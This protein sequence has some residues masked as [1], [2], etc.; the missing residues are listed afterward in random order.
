MRKFV[1]LAMAVIGAASFAPAAHAD[2]T[3][4][5][6]YFLAETS[7][8]TSVGFNGVADGETAYYSDTY[9]EAGVIFSNSFLAIVSSGEATPPN[10]LGVNFLTWRGLDPGTDSLNQTLTLTVT[11]P[12]PVTAFGFDYA[13]GFLNNSD[14]LTITW[15]DYSYGLG[16]SLLGESFFGVVTSEPL[17]SLTI[18]DINGINIY[19]TI[20]N[21]AFE[22]APAQTVPEPASIA[23]LGLAGLATGLIRRAKTNQ[24]EN[25]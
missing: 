20:A 14:V 22:L 12:A 7:D 19:P 1:I 4:S 24:N 15:Q 13:N 2:V 11:F 18:S 23:V 16:E 3:A 10:H 6:A 25:I 5:R 9:I 17:S 8:D 21:L